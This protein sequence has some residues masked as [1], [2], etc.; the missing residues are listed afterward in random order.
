[1]K[2]QDRATADATVGAF[3]KPENIMMMSTRF[4]LASAS[5]LAVA[6]AQT[7]IAFTSVPAEVE[8]GDTYNI[9]WGGGNDSVSVEQGKGGTVVLTARQPVTLTLRKGDPNDLETIEVLADGV[10]GSSYEWKVDDDLESD[11]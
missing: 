2:H 10:R 7:K 6:L 4:V 1:M 3:A 11:K 5:L 8:A 9:T